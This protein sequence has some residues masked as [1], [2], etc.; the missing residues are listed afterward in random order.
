MYRPWFSVST[1]T[2]RRTWAGW[3]TTSKPGHASALPALGLRIE[4][5]M[6]TVVVLPAP[7]GPSSAMTSPDSTL[8]LT[9]F[10]RLKRVKAL[11]ECDGLYHAEHFRRLMIRLAFGS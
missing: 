3:R 9:E 8:K 6:R 11:R 7:F 5:S 4:V 1:P 2:L 10:N